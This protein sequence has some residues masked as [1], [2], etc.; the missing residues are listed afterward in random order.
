MIFVA[1]N[2][3]FYRG[4]RMTPVVFDGCFGWLHNARGDTG[5]VLCNP[6]GH[7]ALW[8][9]RSWRGLA[10]HL[11]ANGMPALRFDYRGT[12]DS[13]QSEDDG[14]R[15]DAWVSSVMDAVQYLR[16][17][18]G[19]KR[20]VLCGVRLGGMVASLAAQR[21]GDIDGLVLMAP[22][23][24]GKGYLRELKLMHRRWRNTSA[25]H[26]AVETLSDGIIET[27]GYRLN[28]ET[29]ARLEALSLLA[30]GGV[31]GVPQVLIMDPVKVAASDKLRDRFAQ[32]G[33]KVEVSDFAD[34][35]H[36]MSDSI[37]SPAPA[38]SYESVAT[39][40]MALASGSGGGSC[41]RSVSDNVRSG[42][43]TAA[44]D[45]AKLSGDGFIE[46]PVI[47]DSGRLFGVYC[48]P[49]PITSSIASCQSD[50]L[51]TFQ[52]ATGAVLSQQAVLFS[53]TA[54]SHHV[55]EARMWVTHARRLARLGVASLRMDVG[56]LG[57]SAN[58]PVS[59]S[60]ADLHAPQS[61]TDVGAGIDWLV[62][63]GHGRPTAVGICSG[64]YLTLHA[65]A[66]H[67]EIA[68]VT[69]I[70]QREYFWAEGREQA[71]GLAVAST[72]VYMQSVR[73]MEKWKRVLAGETPIV[74]I[75]GALL[76]RRAKQWKEKL[77]Y[78]FGA[79]VGVE[80]AT[81]VVRKKFEALDKRG[82]DVRVTYGS[83]DEGLEQSAAFLGTDFSWVTGLPK[84]EAKTDDSM[85]HALFLYPARQAMMQS[86][87]QQLLDQM[88][89]S[90]D[91]ALSS[92]VTASRG[93][94][95]SHVG[96]VLPDH[97]LA[98]Q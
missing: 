52:A 23:E 97:C 95:Q 81:R 10:E 39:W 18:T 73:S 63:A 19:V 37:S 38:Q 48:Q 78:L 27:V 79:V 70:N 66:A 51:S 49:A 94:T 2:A 35:A 84:A 80:S 64:A 13:A 88:A 20:V 75:V 6:Y 7:E 87:E 54:R 50:S 83:F 92:S 93:T 12:G 36:L 69:L 65:A 11:S 21:L 14:E 76:K 5:V 34:Y 25:P 59:V 85:D 40:V 22:A 16:K 15:V 24:T 68:G 55:G 47:F 77:T 41:E 32:A 86:I 67:K 1:D 44:A 82:V 58:A 30:D 62:A 4:R 17:T 53:N 60:V 8:A 74:A 90:R 71:L 43:A 46:T 72:T 9:H 28:A 91:F 96:G 26:I 33:S 45:T 89:A 3:A 42:Q 61:V 57:D 98:Q 56:L 29:A 31:P